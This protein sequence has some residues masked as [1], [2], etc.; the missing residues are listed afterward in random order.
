MDRPNL[1]IPKI[2]VKNHSPPIIPSFDL[3][4][5]VKSWVTSKTA[6]IP[7]IKTYVSDI[8]SI[9]TSI[10]ALPTISVIEETVTDLVEETVGA[11]LELWFGEEFADPVRYFYNNL[12]QPA[13]N[14]IRSII[15]EAFAEVMGG[16]HD[17]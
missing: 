15:M 3:L 10:S 4:E 2:S 16:I 11:L 5:E 13:E 7:D 6:D 17:G 12:T 1:S 9:I 14:V 8:P